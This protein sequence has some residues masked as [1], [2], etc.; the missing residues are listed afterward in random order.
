[1]L[2]A[3][4]KGGGESTVL[5]GAS[6]DVCGNDGAGRGGGSGDCFAL[7]VSGS[8]CRCISSPC[9]LAAHGG[10]EGGAAALVG[11]SPGVA[12]L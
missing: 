10:G 4:G 8:G 5:T 1:M 9:A 7:L 3:Q 11:S 2:A 6:V 12:A